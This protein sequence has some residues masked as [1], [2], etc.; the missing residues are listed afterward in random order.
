MAW[1]AKRHRV[2]APNWLVL[3]RVLFGAILLSGLIIVVTHVGEL[4]QFVDLLKRMQ[5]IWLIAAMLF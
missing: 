3:R 1:L 2:N 4:R 5:P